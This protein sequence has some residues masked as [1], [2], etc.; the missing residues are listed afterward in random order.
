MRE[1]KSLA[2]RT[3]V[4]KSDEARKKFFSVRRREN[5]TFVF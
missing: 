5:R 2:Q 3:K 4:L 1:R